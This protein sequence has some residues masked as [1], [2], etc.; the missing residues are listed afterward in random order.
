[1]LGEPSARELGGGRFGYVPPVPGGGCTDGEEVG[2]YGLFVSFVVAV[3]V[4]VVLTPSDGSA[5]LETFTRRFLLCFSAQAAVRV[6]L[7]QYFYWLSF[8]VR[9]LADLTAKG[10]CSY[11]LAVN[12]KP[13]RAL[14]HLFSGS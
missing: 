4:L 10:A 8:V 5:L 7:L 13:V 1:V 11:V 14:R 2:Y 12:V 3:S 9:E 6:A